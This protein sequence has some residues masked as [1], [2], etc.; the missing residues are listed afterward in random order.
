[1]GIGFY[2]TF[3]RPG[4]IPRWD[5]VN[6]CQAYCD[7]NRISFPLRLRP[8]EPGDRFSPLG[9]GGTQ[10]IKKYFIDHKIS[11]QIR[12]MTPVLVDQRGIV[13]LVGQRMDNYFRITKETTR[14]LSIE[15]FLLDI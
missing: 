8:V 6:P 4:N 9:A 11:R 15:F 12:S 13:W 1:M 14:V 7:Y 3:H 5:N 10:K 2:F